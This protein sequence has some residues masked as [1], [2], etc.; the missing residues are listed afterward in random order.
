M[1]G[2]RSRSGRAAAKRASAAL[3]ST[4]RAFEGIDD[5]EPVA[6]AVESEP[7][8]EAQPEEDDDDEEEEK[9]NESGE[10]E[11]GDE[12]G[13][14]EPAH[15][16]AED[17]EPSAKEPT[18][19]TEPVIRRKRLGRPPK[20]K[21]PGWDNMITVPASEADT[22]RR[23]GR[24]GWRG[25]GGRRPAPGQAPPKLKQ[26]IDKEGTEVDIVD[27]ECVLPEDPEGETK[28]DKLGNLQGGRQYRCR[29][30]TVKDRG[31]R[32]YML[33]TEPA[34]CVGFRDSYL[35]F[36]KHPKLY[37]IIVSDDE[38]MDM[39]ERNI[40]PHSYKGRAIGIVTARSV[41]VE[42]G[43]RIIVGGR[44]IVD[45]Y[46]VADMR[47]AGVVEG[48]IADP[49][50]VFDPNQPYNSNQYVAWFGASAVYHTNQTPA[51]SDPLAGLT[52][53][54]KKRVNVN[55]TNWQLEHAR[56]ASEFNSRI[57]AIRMA[58]LRHGAYDIHTNLMHQPVNTQPTRARVEAIAPGTASESNSA[59]PT[60][61]SAVQRNF[62]VVDIVYETPRAGVQSAGRRPAEVP[63]FLKPF[64]GIL[65]IS[66]DIKS[67]LPPECRESLE[68]HQ[69]DQREFES[70]FGDEK[71]KMAR[72]RLRIDKS[73]KELVQKHG[74]RGTPNGR[75]ES[76]FTARG[77]NF[78]GRR[79]QECGHGA[80]M[81]PEFYEA[82]S[83]KPEGPPTKMLKTESSQGRMALSESSQG[84]MVKS[85]SF[86]GKIQSDIDA[87][88][89]V[90]KFDS[91][92]GVIKR[93][94]KLVVRPEFHGNTVMLG[95]S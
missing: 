65:A 3:Q 1:S 35:F 89:K 29:T 72:G 52:E 85:D 34:R 19:P 87:Q 58:T 90:M 82:F 17:S 48:A 80:E 81:K 62:N 18:P 70:R 16:D 47:A 88:G 69:A 86:Q 92:Q 51:A 33:S 25:R 27:D 75:F 67:M 61:P 57:N 95:G 55:D 94:A 71:D 5:D 38:K 77:C 21:P 41:F 73:V 45:D 6:E 39:I 66:D 43:A 84:K 11:G 42:F 76:T 54:K 36:N 44:N 83:I 79:I 24:G 63:D 68:R 26:V 23:R 60:V 31:E 49:S 12:D 15:D 64:N 56:A 22:P 20:N 8:H 74:V 53:V 10:E 37:K 50:D 91:P 46:R 7:E 2:R 93:E 9:A 13:E 59:F 28:V 14:E 40:I 78:C 30:F 4:P 32:Q